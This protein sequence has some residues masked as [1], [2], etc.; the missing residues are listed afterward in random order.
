MI[1]AEAGFLVW[2]FIQCVSGVNGGETRICALKG[3]SVDLHCSHQ[4]LTSS[5]KWFTIH[6]NGSVS[7][8]S[9]DGQRVTY[10]MSEEKNPTLTIN[11]LRESDANTYC[12]M[13][14]TDSPG[15]CSLS[16]ITLQVVTE[17]QVKVIPATE[18]QTVTLM[19]SSSCP[20]TEKPAAYIWYKNR[21]FLYEDWSPW[22]QELLSSEEAVTYSCAVK[23]YEH[24]RA[25]EVSVGSITET[26][27]SVTYAKG[28]MCSSQQTSV[29]EP[30]SITYP[31]ELCVQRTSY[32]SDN[33]TLTC[34]NSCNLTDHQTT[35]TWYQNRSRNDKNENISIH[36]SAKDKFSCAVKDHEHLQ[37]A[38]V[39]V[40]D[41]NCWRVN[42][43][44]RR[45]C[46]LEGSS[47]NITSEYSHPDNMKPEFKCWS[48]KWRKDKVEVE[49]LIEA[50][51][52]VEYQDNM[53]NQHILTINNLKKNDSGGYT[54]RF[55]KDHTRWTQSD[56][57][58]VFLIVTE[59][60]V[61]MSPSA[62]MTEG[63]RVTLTCS[64]SCPLT[65]NTNYI[66]YLNSRPLTPR[67]NQNKHLI[68]DPVSREDAGSY[69]CA[70]K[71]NKDIS[72]A[73]KTLTVQSITGTWTPAA[74]GVSAALLL[75]ILLTICWCVRKQRTSAQSPTTESSDQIEQLSLGPVN[76]ISTQPKEEDEVH[77]SR[78]NFKNKHV[79]PL[80]S[81]V[82][83]DQPREQECSHY[84]AVRFSSAG[85]SGV[86]PADTD[87]QT[88]STVK[89]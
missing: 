27:F 78:V 10:N 8:L 41:K 50:A 83:S 75:L 38:E 3:S 16:N 55:H 49:E 69:S 13:K 81:T 17:L 84:A 60:R 56:L 2:G 72:S 18:G 54:F 51:G 73:P 40:Q 62:V 68:L 53:T 4:H 44:S 43:V 66:W 88:Y 30:C 70:V 74:A 29:D 45:I 61:K 82:Q 35:Y 76:D 22:Y 67:E 87:S 63:Q 23:G 47:V 36:I 28:R 1:L 37:S 77:Y 42:Y 32:T 59:L 52:R 64:T 15:L 80:C 46:A 33:V 6:L 58:G 9:V 7:E 11:D 39:C 26:C 34:N 19:C 85:A 86:T 65:D 5:S 48:K 20:L 57:P 21:E 31:R 25:P 24:L 89:L 14:T 12:C 71:T 79:V